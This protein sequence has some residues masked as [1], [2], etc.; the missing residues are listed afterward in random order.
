MVKFVRS[1]GSAICN[2]TPRPSSWHNQHELPPSHSPLWLAGLFALALGGGCAS[3]PRFPTAL[4]VDRL[5]DE[6]V[7][8]FDTDGDK[9]GDY[10][11]YAGPDGRKHALAYADH[12]GGGPGARIELDEINAADCPHLLIA[13][14]GVPFELVDQLYRAGRF[15]L[16][17]PPARVICGYP[18]M[19]DLAL[20]DLFDAG[21]SLGFQAMHYDRS[22]NHVTNGSTSYLSASNS[23]WVSK[24][25]Y[26]CSFWWDVLVYL[27]PQPVFNHEMSDIHKQF[28]RIDAGHAYAY[29]VGTA[30]LGTR[31]GR[32]AILTYLRAVDDLCERLVFERRGRVKITLTADHGHNLVENKLVSFDDLLKRAGYRPASTLRGPRDVVTIAYGLV[33]YAEFF[34]RDAAGVARCLLGHDDVE[35]VCYPD[36]DAVIVADRD[37]CAR[38]TRGAAGFRYD[39]S[40]GDPLRLT[41]ILEPLRRDGKVSADGEIDSAALFQ[42]TLDHYYPDPLVRLWGAFHGEVENTPDVIANLRD[43]ACH[44]SHFFTAMVG[45]VA[46]THGSLN[47]MNSTTFALTML[48]ELPPAMRSAEVL[49]ALERRREAG[50]LPT[51]TGSPAETR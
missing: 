3:A 7:L 8:T 49:P 40:A 39:A 18:A 12:A 34:T 31:G 33:T 9:H 27:N 50:S 4:H 32:D 17:Y 23:P 6:T 29:S 21:H 1:A 26:R 46:S 41:P 48:G 51:G 13:L 38:I 5:G 45:K 11:Q 15:R 30:G 43:G 16:F 20:H 19:T 22:A 37:G 25:S 24:L 10:W 42:A 35:F 28:A 2:H 36:G 47:R 14:D 44:G